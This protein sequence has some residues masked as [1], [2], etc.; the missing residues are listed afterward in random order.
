MRPVIFFFFIL[1][2]CVFSSKA[3]DTIVLNGQPG[4]KASFDIADQV[5]FYEET[6][7]TA[8]SF[9]AIKKQQL[10]PFSKE[11]RI[12]KFSNRPLV[13]QWFRF[14]IKNTSATDTVDLKLGVTA[15]FFTRL[16][17]N[18][19]LIARGG[20]FQTGYNVFERF[21]L[22]VKVA[23]LNMNTYWA[24][25]EDR[26]EQILDASITLDTPAGFI[27]GMANGIN[28]DRYLF[29]LLAGMA[30]CLFFVCVFALY[31]YFLYRDP[32]F[33]WYIVYAF[34]SLMVCLFW[35]DI[36]LQIM[37]FPALLRD[38]M[39]S[40]FLFI[41]PVLYA[42][43]IG[44]MLKLPVHFKKAWMFVK[45]L[46]VIAFLQMLTEFLVVRTGRFIF[47]VDYYGYFLSMGPVIMLHLLLI[48]LTVK[49]KDPVKWFLFTGLLSM[50]ILW[51]L[52]ITGIFGLV[53]Y[54][55]DELFLILV[56]IPVY[57][58]LGIT[59]EA[60]CFSFALSYRGKLIL[61]EKNNMQELHRLQLEAALE[62]RTL[63]LKE[64][65]N[66]V[67]KQKLQHI[68]AEFDQ[69]IAETE[70]MALR[71]QMNPHFIF[72]C[73][74]SIKLYTTQNDTEA[75]ATYLTKFSRL[76]RMALENSRSERVTLTTELEA[77]EL[78]IQM[79]AMRF[80]D[81]L[82][83]N[84]TVDTKVD[85]YFIE[86]PP[87]LLQPYVENAIWH[88]LMHKDEG[89]YV[90]VNVAALPG[91]H[92]LIIT[93]KDNG[94]GRKRSAELSGKPATEHTSYGTKLTSERLELINQ[95]YK[96]GASVITEDV[97][98]DMGM[99]AGTFVTI[100]IPFE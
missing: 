12:E 94:V 69:K 76:I 23:P 78:Y 58:I 50:L 18:D 87:L 65:S 36:R 3:Q 29:L 59:I 79:E 40:T 19:K 28:K 92:T 14:T 24:R 35:M 55:Y 11:F 33:K 97:I 39:F 16:Y 86:I 4:W 61:V 89:G 30:G 38:I 32:A 77:L 95:L 9:E 47:N 25:T 44:S 31:Q 82:K 90:H 17:C 72:N 74:N 75:A 20:V 64:Q 48:I 66:L 88:G 60:I 93:V 71:S 21:G 83:Y 1:L 84:I 81:K 63:E 7:D 2:I 26:K 43:F 91:E 15:H 6:T 34:M 70:M 56:F 68:Q 13:I 67:E 22:P 27:N 57:L 96:T 100:K 99:I 37:M 85:S 45:I 10:I 62:K 52:P 8:L 46:L 51:C 53:P 42:L 80:K 73:L 5:L 98:D 49:S 41:I 54:K